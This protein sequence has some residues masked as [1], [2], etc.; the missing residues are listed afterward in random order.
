M[1]EASVRNVSIMGADKSVS[2]CYVVEI[3][4]G[5]EAVQQ[6]AFQSMEHVTKFIQDWLKSAE[7]EEGKDPNPGVYG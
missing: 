1:R 3:S 5:E 7:Q 4:D 6:M 2:R